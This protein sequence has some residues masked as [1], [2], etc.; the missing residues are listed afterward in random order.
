MGWQQFLTNCFSLEKEAWKIRH[1]L[2]RI[3]TPLLRVEFLELTIVTF[4]QIG[5]L[6]KETG[7]HAEGNVFINQV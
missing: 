6:L 7:N 1:T 4:K 2:I 5:G 3:K